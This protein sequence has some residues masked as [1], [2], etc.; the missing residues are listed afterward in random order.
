MA[1]E[2]P[3]PNGTITLIDAVQK[4]DNLFVR[5]AMKQQESQEQLMEGRQLFMNV[6]RVYEQKLE[7]QTQAVKSKDANIVDL[8]NYC[9]GLEDIMRKSNIQIDVPKPACFVVNTPHVEKTS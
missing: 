4:L 2:A 9:I 8:Q 5:G 7:E 3:A 6:I 1:Q